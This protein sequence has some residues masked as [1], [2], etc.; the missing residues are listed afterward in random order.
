M[1]IL[2]VDD[3]RRPA[4]SIKM[5]FETKGHEVCWVTNERRTYEDSTC[6]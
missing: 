6:R 4:Q 5:Y 2:I 3:D 1:R